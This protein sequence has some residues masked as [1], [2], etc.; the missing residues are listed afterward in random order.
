MK[1][2][3]VLD[4]LFEVGRV[5]MYVY[6]MMILNCKCTCT[7]NVHMCNS[8]RRSFYFF[9]VSSPYQN[10]CT[11]LHLACQNG[12]QDVVKTLLAGGAN[13]NQTVKV[14][15]T[16]LCVAHVFRLSDITIICTLVW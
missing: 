1:N 16:Y 10:N 6:M 11:P 4:Q 15:N 2:S 7:S 13:V 5:Y 9:F 14:C 8:G 3:A 12:H